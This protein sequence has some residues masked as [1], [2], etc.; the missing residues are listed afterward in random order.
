[1]LFNSII[2]NAQSKKKIKREMDSFIGANVKD[3]FFNYS[4]YVSTEHKFDNEFIVSFMSKK[5]I[6][7]A[8]LVDAGSGLRVIQQMPSVYYTYRIFHVNAN[9]VVDKWI[10]RQSEI[11][12]DRLQITADMR[13]VMLY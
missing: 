9:G 13:I 1:M 5:V 6:H 3:L 4:G 11:P 12:P 10:Y 8:S 2:V 7:D